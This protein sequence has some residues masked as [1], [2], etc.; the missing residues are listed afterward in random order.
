MSAFNSS[1]AIEKTYYK[2]KQR[3]DTKQNKIL[4]ENDKKRLREQARDKLRKL[5][6]EETN[7]KRKYGRS[8]CHNMSKEKK[9]KLKEY[10]K[11]YR[12]ARELK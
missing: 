7:E 2:K 3:R 12:E 10:Q 1:A 8:R 6:E 9:Q 4:F 11:H 5:S